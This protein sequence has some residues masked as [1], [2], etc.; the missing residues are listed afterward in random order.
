MS[1]SLSGDFSLFHNNFNT[2]VIYYHLCCKTIAFMTSQVKYTKCINKNQNH[3]DRN[4]SLKPRFQTDWID[5]FHP[6]YRFVLLEASWL[7]DHR[8]IVKSR[9]RK[10]NEVSAIN[11]PAVARAASPPLESSLIGLDTRAYVSPESREVLNCPLKSNN[12][13]Y[14]AK[15]VQLFRNDWFIVSTRPDDVTAWWRIVASF[16]VALLTTCVLYL[17]WFAVAM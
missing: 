11:I 8:P 4:F 10:M 3:L 1:V 13:D 15:L 6:E 7:F 2:W 9:W 14:K 5:H 16:R 12:T 17:L